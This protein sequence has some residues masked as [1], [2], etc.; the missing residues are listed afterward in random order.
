MNIDI[1][2]LA[3]FDLGATPGVDDSIFEPLRSEEQARSLA[4][5]G[6][7]PVEQPMPEGL[8]MN[9]GEGVTYD[10]TGTGLTETLTAEAR[11]IMADERKGDDRVAP[12]SIRV[13]LFPLG[14]AY[15]QVDLQPHA[16]ADPGTALDV[17]Q[18]Y[19][20]AAYGDF[21]NKLQS[22]MIDLLGQINRDDRLCRLTDRHDL[23]KVAP[24][25]LIPGFTVLLV[26]SRDHPRL[27]AFLDVFSRYERQYPYREMELDDGRVFLGWASTVFV[28]R[29]EERDRLEW[30]LKTCLV[31][32]GVCA[33]FEKVFRNH[34]IKAARS[35][36]TQGS[37]AYDIPALHRLQILA[38]SIPLL[39][40]FHSSTN[41][42]SDL[43]LFDHFNFFARIDK[44]HERIRSSSAI[45]SKTQTGLLRKVEEDRASKINNFI[46]FLTGFTFISVVADIINTTTSANRL[47]PDPLVRLLLLTAPPLLLMFFIWKRFLSR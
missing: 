42:I 14:V 36:F 12:R 44:M 19:E 4:R 40:D 7:V 33:A 3:S 41:N 22:L 10:L 47:L 20:Y 46:F 18:A 28:P 38:S 24:F 26:A 15:L 5:R 30:L 29:A 37:A 17:Y 2:M 16:Y 23:A 6:M 27:D 11:R 9:I 25:D 45:F 34:M 13:T 1:S 43:C 21:S 39:T 8:S 31:Y 32:H 35:Q